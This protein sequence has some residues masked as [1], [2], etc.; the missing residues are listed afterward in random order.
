ME[1]SAKQLKSDGT[2]LSIIIPVYNVGD[3]LER[4]LDS[5]ISTK[6]IE[7]TEIIIVDD[8]STDIS[9]EIADRYSSEFGFINCFHKT[10]G[11]LSD[12][13]NYGLERASGKYVFFLDS[14]DMV[15]PS[16]M[17]KIIDTA[18][19]NDADVLLWDG[20]TINEDDSVIPSELDRILV[21][22]GLPQNSVMTGVEA[23]V[24]QIEDHNK[25]S[26]TAWLR[27]VRRDFL[28]DNY[29]LFENGLIH[30]DELWTPQVMCHAE[31]VLY[32]PEKAYC[33]RIR[34]N[35]IT[36]SDSGEE[37]AKAFIRIMDELYELYT[38]KITDKGC[39]RI[40]LGN[41]ADT[42]FWE[43]KSLEFYKFECRNQ[44]PRRKILKS[45][46]GFKNK[47]KGLILQV[48]GVRTYCRMAGSSR[49]KTQ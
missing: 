10:N 45:A 33:Y 24:K 42:Y 17:E 43:I 27:A 14:D 12:A 20:V 6:G 49:D 4:C 13:R 18:D 19:K 28:K 29:L 47:M 7:D 11:G 30:E 26:M 39:Q 46:K 3:Y 38:G 15:I 37:H 41:W 8:G 35:S 40:L 32:I 36:N 9:G 2:I 31:K 44:L 21:H 16:A 22:K 34:E 25:A 23:M 48:F 5:L 1:S